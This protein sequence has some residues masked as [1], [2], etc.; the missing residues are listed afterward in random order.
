MPIGPSTA[1]QLM[2]IILVES[3]REGELTSAVTDQSD[4]AAGRHMIMSI[5]R[6]SINMRL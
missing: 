4:E 1:L 5:Y 3:R 6:V 2:D